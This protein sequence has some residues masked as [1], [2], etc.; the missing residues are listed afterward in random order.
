MFTTPD[1]APTCAWS[2]SP[3]AVVV[4][5]TNP[6]PSPAAATLTPLIS[7]ATLVSCQPATPRPWSDDDGPYEGR[8]YQLAETL[9]VPTPLGRSRPPIVIGGGG[10]KKTLRLVARYADACNLFASSVDQVAHKL[11]VLRAH[12]DSEGRSYDAI[13]KT[14]MFSRPVLK[15]IDSFMAEAEAYERLG[16][17]EIQVLPDRHPVA[18]T[19]QVVAQVAPRVAALG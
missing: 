18:F 10:E 6:A 13:E 8:H 19:K 15:D 1:T 5:V 14:V 11:D 12:C 9:C 7:R 4:E 2:T 16:V 3:S 17:A